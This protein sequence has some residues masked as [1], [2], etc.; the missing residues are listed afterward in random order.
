MKATGLEF[1]PLIAPTTPPDRAR[2][3]LSG[4]GGFVYYIM[5]TGVTGT[6]SAVAGEV[7]AHVERLR[8]C[9]TLPIA[10][11]FGVASGDQARAVGSAADAVVVGSALINAANEDRLA[12]LVDELSAAL[13]S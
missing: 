5:V 11:G 10:V 1:I 7:R 6:C 13:E 9:T 8:E 3:I 12:E 4:A 2:M